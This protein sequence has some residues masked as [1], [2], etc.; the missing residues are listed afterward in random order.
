M[1]L[2]LRQKDTYRDAEDEPGHREPDRRLSAVC[3]DEVKDDNRPEG[4]THHAARGEETHAEARVGRLRASDRRPDGVESRRPEPADHEQEE[5][6]PELGSNADQTQERGRHQ[7]AEASDNPQPD[8]LAERT[9]DGLRHG[10]A[11]QNTATIRA[12]VVG[13]ASNRT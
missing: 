12:R 11:I 9:E 8:V 7:D 10:E 5:D 3:G 13:P 4:E 6:E 2:P 1:R